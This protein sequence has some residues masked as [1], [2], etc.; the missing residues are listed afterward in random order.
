MRLG[1]KESYGVEYI[2][3]VFEDD[4]KEFAVSATFI[5][6]YNKIK[7]SVPSDG[8]LLVPQEAT[9]NAV[10]RGVIVFCGAISGK[11]KI[12]TD[13]SFVVQNHSGTEG[14]NSN[15]SP[16]VWEQFV[17]QVKGYSDSAKS[18]AEKA[19]SEARKAEQ[20]VSNILQSEENAEQSAEKAA[21]SANSAA[22]SAK[23]ASGELKKVQNASTEALSKI[24]TAKNDAVSAVT[25]TGIAQTGKVESAGTEALK[26]IDTSKTSAV[27]AVGAAGTQAKQDIVSA[28]QS[29]L[30]A[31][32][33]VEGQSTQTVQDEGEKQK[34]AVTESGDAKLEEIKAAN[35]ILPAPTKNDVGKAVI[36][37]S[38]GNS[39]ELGTTSSDGQCSGGVITDDDT[40]TVYNAE[41][42]VQ[43]GHPVL[44]LK[45]RS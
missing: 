20:A 45:E 34:Q 3:V 12:T 24:G 35:S 23:D 30:K 2:Q 10:D 43:D 16:S 22:Q 21:S 4:W 41:L 27:N 29:A 17:S 31:I 28:K 37:S 26:V 19:S 42:R 25:E 33:D 36:V 5:T 44:I 13:L 11:Q 9:K 40:G 38:D 7:M 6:P 32:S 18:S 1:T 39:Y 8:L 14:T 15:P